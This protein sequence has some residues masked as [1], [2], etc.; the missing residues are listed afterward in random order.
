LA[1]DVLVQLQAAHELCHDVAAFLLALSLGGR[2][3][4]SYRFVD[5]L[6][7]YALAVVGVTTPQLAA[8][9]PR[10][11]SAYTDLAKDCRAAFAEEDIQDGQDMP[12]RCRGPAG[13]SILISF[14]AIG[15]YIEVMGADEKYMME[16][17]L[18]LADYARGKVEWRMADGQPFAVIVR[19]PKGEDYPETLAV[20]G[21]GAYRTLSERV[22]VAGNRRANAQARALADRAR[23]AA[24]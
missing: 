6:F 24:R 21:I 22:P 5:V 2:M 14:A 16:G 15:A 4:L 8:A 13:L 9:A 1:F 10:F 11:E 23:Q 19:T 17:T 18:E 12:L 3:S 20:Q 7:I